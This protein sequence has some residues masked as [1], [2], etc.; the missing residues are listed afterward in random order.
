MSFYQKYRPKNLSQIKGNG[1]LVSALEGMLG[2]LENCPHSFLL[3]GPTGCGKTTL[4]RIIANLLGCSGSD[5]KEID[6][7]Q[8][9]GIDTAREIRGHSQYMAME[10]DCRVWIIDECHKMTNDAQN[11]LLKILEDTPSH[12]YFVLCTTEPQKLLATIKGRCSTFQV[13]PLGEEDMQLLLK[14]IVRREKE[15]LSDEVYE[16]I[17]KVSQGLPRNAIQT[18]EQVLKTPIDKRVEI[19]QKALAEQSESIALCRALMKGSAWKEVS[20]ILSGLRDQ[21][22]ESIRRG[23]LGYCQ[24]TLLRGDVMLAGRIMEEFIN[25]FYDSGFPQLVFACYSVTK[26]K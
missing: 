11:G 4:A 21:D 14:R 16:V 18:L 9:R 7:A 24:N 6:S 22:P 3:H 10:S 25:P 13:K 2:D 20:H 17:I 15:E 5:L 19:A 12:V 26:N 1:E 8:F 23:V